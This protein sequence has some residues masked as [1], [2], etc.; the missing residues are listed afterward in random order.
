MP[1]AFAGVMWLAL[2]RR[3]ASGRAKPAPAC[4]HFGW[5][6]L[7]SYLGVHQSRVHRLPEHVR[8]AAADAVFEQ[9]FYGDSVF[10]V[11]VWMWLMLGLGALV[12]RAGGRTWAAR[13]ALDATAVYVAAMMVSADRA[14]ATVKSRWTETVGAAPAADDGRS[15]ADHSIQKGDHRRRRR[16]V[17]ASADSTGT[18]GTSASIPRRSRRTIRDR[19]C[20]SRS[21]R[22]RTSRRSSSGHAFR[23]GSSKKTATASASHCATFASRK[24]RS[25]PRRRAHADNSNFTTPNSQTN[26]LRRQA[27]GT[28]DL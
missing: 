16:P 5:L 14:R 20:G 12:A 23:I 15:G 22:S 26:S 4:P 1:I 11:D 2:G 13:T 21:R 10:I 6:V 9:W 3:P 24:P 7:L 27:S 17:R 25:S 28:R 19:G 8:R 18:R